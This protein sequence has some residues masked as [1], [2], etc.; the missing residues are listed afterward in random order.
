VDIN[1]RARQL[2]K[3]VENRYIYTP[4]WKRKE[5]HQRRWGAG[6]NY[7]RNAGLVEGDWMIM[8]Q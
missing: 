8:Q 2:P 3:G 1:T 6:A 5:K 4:N 7:N